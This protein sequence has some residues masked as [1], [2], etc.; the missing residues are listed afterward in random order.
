MESALKRNM[1]K[2]RPNLHF[3][4]FGETF[5][6]GPQISMSGNMHGSKHVE[7]QQID[8]SPFKINKDLYKQM[9]IKRNKLESLEGTVVQN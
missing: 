7:I 1:S 2:K 6:E 9:I 4:Y 3:Q 5:E 8:L